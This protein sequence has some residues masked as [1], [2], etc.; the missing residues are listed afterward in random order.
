MISLQDEE[1]ILEESLESINFESTRSSLQRD[2]Q[3]ITRKLNQTTR[4]VAKCGRILKMAKDPNDYFIDRERNF[5]L[6]HGAY[7]FNLM[8]S[9]VQLVIM[10]SGTP[11]T[12]LLTRN[13]TRIEAP[14]PIP[15]GMR[16]VY[17]TPVGKMSR[18]NQDKTIPLMAARIM[19]IHRACPKNT[20]VHAHSFGLIDKFRPYMKHRAVMFQ[21]QGQREES[22][23]KF[24]SSKESIWF[25]AAYAQGLSLMG[26]QFQRNIIAKV[27][28]P[29]LGEWVVKRNESDVAKIG[30]DMWYRMST[31]VDIQ[32]AAGRCTR[33][34]TDYSETYILDSNFGYFFNQNK[35][36][37][38]QWFKDALVWER[39]EKPVSKRRKA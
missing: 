9:K 12:K 18:D 34:P 8:A 25:S 36:F 21:E 19:E 7:P 20:L 6:L 29:G 39:K 35:Q 24:L 23:N 30:M 32:Q 26:S 4:L 37:F 17:Y 11:T 38:E 33:S 28:Y 2:I 13:F 22:L 10:S 27:P 15:I 31:A 5:K 1:M 16:K 14:H 3:N